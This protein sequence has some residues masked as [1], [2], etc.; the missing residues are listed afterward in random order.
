M[1]KAGLQDEDGG[2]WNGFDKVEVVFDSEVLN[3]E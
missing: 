3:T 1:Q 2:G